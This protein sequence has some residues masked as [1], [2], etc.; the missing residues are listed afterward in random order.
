MSTT[1]STNAETREAEYSILGWLLKNN[2]KNEK[3]DPLVFH[4]RLYLLDVL[5]DW[6]QEIVI[7]KASQVGGSL[8]FNLKVM[9]AVLKF[10]WN[11]IYTFPSDNDVQEFVK[12]KT[13]E[14]IKQNASVFAGLDGDSISMKEFRSGGVSRFLFFKGTVS[15]T[16]A[17]ATTADA[18]VHDEAS[19]SD[20]PTLETY[21][22]RTKASKYKRRWLFSNPTTDKDAV[23]IA[24]NKSDQKEWTITCTGCTAS[25]VMRWPESIDPERKVFQC[26]ECRKELTRE[27]RRLGTWVAKYPERKISGYHMSHFMVL[28][29][30][31]EEILTDSE[32]DQQYFYNFVLGEPYTPGDLQV[33]RS[34]ILDNWTPRDLT[35]G[36]WYLGV[37]VGNIK[38]YVLGSELGVTKVGRFTAWQEL[39]DIM[40]FYKPTLV[41]DAMPDNT[42]SKYFVETYRNSLMSFFQENK[43]NPQ[44]LVW[45]GEGDRKGIVYSNRNRILDQLIDRILN[46][47]ILFGVPSDKDLR[48]YVAHWE[49]LRRVKVVDTKGIESYEWDSTTGVDHYV[50]AT[51][52]YYLAR[53]GDGN[54]TFLADGAR[55]PD[56]IGRDNVVGDISQAFADANGLDYIV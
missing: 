51:L 25:Q 55:A 35:T 32:A 53:L 8:I 4:D 36:K 3:G 20:Q 22:S 47:E 17:I 48:D 34:T 29:I 42:M 28:D 56:F 50:F 15:K 54:G 11:V 26:V 30:S 5:T 44:M 21:K 18:L 40:K 24:W 45:W 49:T 7:K 39:D 10:G 31:A 12:S 27:E 38:H 46:A 14:I 41:I 9:F 52:Y 23:D 13:N 1:S 37:D 6:N 2:V 19:R 33:S 43:N 16:A